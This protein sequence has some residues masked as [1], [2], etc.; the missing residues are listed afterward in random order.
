M[1]RLLLPIILLSVFFPAAAEEPP[2]NFARSFLDRAENFQ[3]GA[4]R[5]DTAATENVTC[6]VH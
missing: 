5:H 4:T 2:E 3:T 1:R 6:A